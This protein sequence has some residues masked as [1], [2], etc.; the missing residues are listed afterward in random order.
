MRHRSL[1][2]VRLLVGTLK[3]PALSTAY[4][5]PPNVQIGA[6]APTM[7][8]AD[9]VV[10]SPGV[11]SRCPRS[12][13]PRDARRAGEHNPG[14]SGPIARMA[15]P[16]GMRYPV[17]TLGYGGTRGTGA[18]TSLRATPPGNHVSNAGHGLFDSNEVMPPPIILGVCYAVSATEA[19]NLA[20]GP[21]IADVSYEM[22]GPDVA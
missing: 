9:L 21:S 1:T 2:C 19:A 6:H 17:L 12:R 14:C 3:P 11:I 13:L 20:T 22:S 4:I 10:R 5:A 8:G 7:S 15:L 18:S 16:H